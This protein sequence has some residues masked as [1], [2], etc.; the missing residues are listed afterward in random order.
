MAGD[1]DRVAELVEAHVRSFDT[2]IRAAVTQRL[3]SPLAG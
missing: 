1:G 3:A 2:D